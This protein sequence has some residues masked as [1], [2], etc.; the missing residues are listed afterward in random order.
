MAEAVALFRRA[1]REGEEARALARLARE[2]LQQR[3]LDAF[4]RAVDRAPDATAA[5]R[6]PRVLGVLANALGV[7][8]MAEQPGLARR[9]LL[10]DL[11]DPRS[12][13]N[14]LPD[15][16]W[17][18]AAQTLQLGERGIAALRDPALQAR[19][20]EGLQRAAWNR[21]LE[22]RSPGLGDAVLFQER[23]LGVSNPFELLGNAVLRRVVT[24][25][26]GLPQE[27]AVQSVEAQ[28]R[29][30]TSRLDMSRLSDPREVQ[31]L[32]ERYLSTRAQQGADGAP[33]WMSAA[34]ARGINLLA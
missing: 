11:N 27:I 8:Q 25:A 2:P 30:I 12:A 17:R 7:P 5:L 4:R 32:A 26:L 19:L 24:G 14:V 18:S 33:G 9:V 31:R 6:D 16:R 10:S 1:I 28:A 3:A 34:A 29:A 15:R 21:E 22:S 23:A 20:A 13:A